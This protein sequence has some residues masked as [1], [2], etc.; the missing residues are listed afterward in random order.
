MRMQVPSSRE[1]ATASNLSE[2][3]DKSASRSGVD[4]FQ[5]GGGAGGDWY[6]E[7]A[8]DA[9]ISGRRVQDGCTEQT[10]AIANPAMMKRNA[11]LVQLLPSTTSILRLVEALLAA[12]AAAVPLEV[13]AVVVIVVAAAAAVA[14]AAAF[15]YK[16]AHL[17]C[18]II[19]NTQAP[20]TIE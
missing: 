1:Y 9:F 17:R 4:Y 10:S 11:S 12:A 18:R 14:T 6:I 20:N 16:S 5:A 13:V 3:V 15:R 7:D 19:H 8:V 2:R